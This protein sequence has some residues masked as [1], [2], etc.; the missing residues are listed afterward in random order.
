MNRLNRIVHTEKSVSFKKYVQIS[1]NRLGAIEMTVLKERENTI[2]FSIEPQ[3]SCPK[4]SYPILDN[5]SSES[6]NERS[7]ER[8]V[9]FVCKPRTDNQARQWAR[10]IRKGVK[11]I[12]ELKDTDFTNRFPI[13]QIKQCSVQHKMSADF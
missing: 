2:C 11:V 6:S 5:T 7:N 1:H 10:Q 8:Q 9:D 13:K 12:R 4:G 3:M